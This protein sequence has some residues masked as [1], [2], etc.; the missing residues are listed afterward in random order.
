[1]ED[2]LEGCHCLWFPQRAMD[3]QAY[4]PRDQARIQRSSSSFS[5]LENT[6]PRRLELSGAR[7]PC[8]PKGRRS[9]RTLEA[10]QVACYKKKPEDLVPTS[11]SSMK[12][13]FCS[14]RRDVEHG[15]FKAKRPSSVT[16]ISTKR[17]RHW[18]RSPFR[19]NANTSVCTLVFSRTISRHSMWPTFF[20]L[21]CEICVATSFSCGTTLRFTRGRT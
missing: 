10:L 19:P 16:A 9:H 4:S 21:S 15:D 3:A 7:A 8:D 13:A 20:A 12:A 1:M 11:F 6:A 5:C 2:P 18:R 14:F 17:S